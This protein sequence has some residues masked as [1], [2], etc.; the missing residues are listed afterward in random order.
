MKAR[1][2]TLVELIFVIVI[3]GIIAITILPKYINLEHDAKAA[4]L[5]GLVAA[6]E[7]VTHFTY[8]E[9]VIHGT[10]GSFRTVAPFDTDVG[11]DEYPSAKTNLG[12]LELKYGYPEADPEFA[13]GMIELL[14][15]SSDEWDI[16][17]G[18]SDASCQSSGEASSSHVRVGMGLVDD[19]GTATQSKCYVRYIEPGGTDNDS[20]YKYK[21]VVEDSDC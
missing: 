3:I 11:R 1:G 6:M 9:A 10:Q 17:Y 19:D 12:Y 4:D 14:D 20:E 7:S 2:F 5:N 21:I 15:L 16:C 13:L 8:S 18:S